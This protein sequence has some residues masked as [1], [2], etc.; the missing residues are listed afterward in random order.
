M[1]KICIV[2]VF[3][4]N[5]LKLQAETTK[6]SEIAPCPFLVVFYRI[7]EWLSVK[8]AILMFFKFLHYNA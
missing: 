6:L 4:S 5:V 7:C 8:Q 1:K 3:R 2:E